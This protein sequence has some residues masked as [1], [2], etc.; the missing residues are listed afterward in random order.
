MLLDGAEVPIS[1]ATRWRFLAI[2][3]GGWAWA[4]A[5]S[6]E[7]VS[8]VYAEDIAGGKVTIKP[9]S[10][11]GEHTWTC[12]RGTKVVKQPNPEPR[13]MADYGTPVDAERAT[14][15]LRGRLGD[16]QLELHTIER[17]FPLLRGFRFVQEM[18]YHR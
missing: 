13:T 4:R 11:G 6:G 14:L 15:V 5:L 1:D 12:E 7:M 10:G 8:F 18:P 16:K 9:R 3:R 17:V 2:D